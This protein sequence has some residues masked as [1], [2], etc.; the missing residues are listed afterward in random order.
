MGWANCGLDS[1][2]RSIGYAHHATCDHPGC[3][4]EIDRGLS[5]ACGAMH[6][7]DEV[8]CEKYFCEVHR[9]MIRFNGRLRSI[10]T[11]CE[12]A[13]RAEYPDEA[14]AFDEE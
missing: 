10:C 11:E 8:S 12:A 4:A 3:E 14:G 13:W 9:N 2:G 1:Q 5:Y 6:D 7:D